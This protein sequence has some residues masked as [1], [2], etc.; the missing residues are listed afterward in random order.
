MPSLA[1]G[2]SESPQARQARAL[3]PDGSLGPAALGAG[4]AGGSLEGLTD[5][6]L[7]VSAVVARILA[8]PM[9]HPDV[10]D[11]THETLRR[12]L[13]GRSRLREGEPLRPWVIGIARHVALDARRA[14]RRP[15]RPDRGDDDET[16]EIERLADPAPGPDDRA[17]SLQRVHLVDRAMAD[18]PAGTREA[19]QLFH[20]DGLAYRAIAER[21]GV[22]LGTVAT[23]VARGRRA[24]AEALGEPILGRLADH[25]SIDG[26][27]SR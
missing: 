9:G 21:L 1:A 18:L 27:R 12:A 2:I 20:V 26:R 14:R 22:P 8:A 3:A 5:L 10:E 7:V 24:I 13:E 15:G 25:G 11:C 19:L 4:S 6:R 23:W 17:A 16:P